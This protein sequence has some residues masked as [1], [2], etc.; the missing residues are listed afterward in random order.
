MSL[1]SLT[2]ELLAASRCTL[3]AEVT[4]LKKADRRGWLGNGAF[5]A[6][7]LCCLVFDGS[8]DIDRGLVLSHVS[9]SVLVSGVAVSVGVAVLGSLY[10]AAFD[11]GR[12]S[13]CLLTSI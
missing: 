7:L 11:T 3:G 9:L 2:E 13:T 10:C 12:S 1:L 8:S 4:T 5:G 6:A